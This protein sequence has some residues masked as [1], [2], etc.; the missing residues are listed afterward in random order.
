VLVLFILRWS[1]LV[2]EGWCY[3]LC[4]ALCRAAAVALRRPSQAG[5]L[6]LLLL[7]V[8]PHK[9]EGCCYCCSP[10]LSRRSMQLACCSSLFP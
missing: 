5:G 8:A 1:A 7:S 6:L 10:S 3:S 9:L 2:L 4:Q